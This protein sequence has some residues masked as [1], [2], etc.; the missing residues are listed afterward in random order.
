MTETL[1]AAQC[2]KIRRLANPP[3]RSPAD[4]GGELNVVPYLDIIMNIMMF[5]LVS[6]SVAF[7]A[8]I[9]TAAAQGRPG[10]TPLAGLRLTALV[11]GDGVAIKTAGGGLAPGCEQLGGGLTVPNRGGEVDVAA[12]AACARRIKSQPEAAQETQVT[13]TASPNVPY[14][15]VVRV[16]DALRSDEG[17]ELFPNVTLGAVR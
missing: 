9:P 2:A 14:E 16:M 17:G 6:V 8:T 10:G 4:E 5:V 3:E 13:L 7:T 15:V 12:L 11:T 1:S